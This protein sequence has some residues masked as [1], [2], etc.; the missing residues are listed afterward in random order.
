[1]LFGQEKNIRR[2]MKENSIG[3]HDAQIIDTDSD[4]LRAK[5]REFGEY[6]FEKRW[7][8]GFNLYEAIKIMRERNYFGSMMVEK[9]EADALISGLTRKYSDTIRPA[10][11]TIGMKSGVKR[12]AG[13]DSILHHKCPLD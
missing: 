7:R 11:Q 4:D 12:L 8:R 9:G 13:M 5:R 2:L 3:V 10:L 1:M 6:F